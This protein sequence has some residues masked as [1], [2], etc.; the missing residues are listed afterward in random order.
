MCVVGGFWPKDSSVVSDFV[1]VVVRGESFL[2]R[3]VLLNKMF[4][5][6]A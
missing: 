3:Q 2:C 5:N 1:F 4:K 6:A